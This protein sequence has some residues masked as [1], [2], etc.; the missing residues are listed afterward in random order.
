METISN[1]R[2]VGTNL[3]IYARQIL[4]SGKENVKVYE[5]LGMW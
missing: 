4:L 2:G 3:V 5:V 1:F